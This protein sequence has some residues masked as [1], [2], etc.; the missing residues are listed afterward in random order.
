VG[1]KL[2]EGDAA[3][4]ACEFALWGRPAQ[5]PPDGDWLTWLLLAG[6]GN[7]KTRSGAE[8]VRS[9]MCGT[10]PLAAGQWRHVATHKPRQA[11]TLSCEAVR[12]RPPQHSLGENRLK[13][14]FLA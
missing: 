6:R 4:L 12:G 14:Q 5:F 13:T 11:D 8:F 7:G 1:A 10:T 2:A 9:R 3:Q